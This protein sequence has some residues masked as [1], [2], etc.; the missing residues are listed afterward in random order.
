M[1]GGGGGGGGCDANTSSRE[2]KKSSIDMLAEIQTFPSNVV[3]Q[4]L[5]TKIFNRGRMF[6]RETINLYCLK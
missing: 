5:G 2:I 3:N 6:C 4:T 1:C